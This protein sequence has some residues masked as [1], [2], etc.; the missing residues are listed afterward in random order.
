VLAGMLDAAV[1]DR[2][3]PSSPAR[4]V[5]LPRK[6]SKEH[7]YLT[8]LQVKRIDSSEQPLDSAVREILL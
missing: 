6:V 1:K 3:I 5:G 4:G 2:R 8:H 7:V